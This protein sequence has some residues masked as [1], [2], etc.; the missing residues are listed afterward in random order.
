MSVKEKKKIDKLHSTRNEMVI[1]WLTWTARKANGLVLEKS[2]NVKKVV[3]SYK[4]QNRP[5]GGRF[6]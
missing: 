6:P 2:R 4:D 1:M 3:S 5:V